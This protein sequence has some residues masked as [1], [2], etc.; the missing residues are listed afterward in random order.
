METYSLPILNSGA[1]Y[2]S[3]SRPGPKTES[4]ECRFEVPAIFWFGSSKLQCA[5][6]CTYNQRKMVNGYLV[7]RTA[8]GRIY[9]FVVHCT[10][11][12]SSYFAYPFL[13]RWNV[14]HL[15]AHDHNFAMLSRDII[16][17]N[18]W[19]ENK[20]IWKSFATNPL[21]GV[22]LVG[23]SRACVLWIHIL[24]VSQF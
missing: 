4:L 24:P 13:T 8:N 14:Q 1:F 12:V 20:D 7:L 22:I 18:D 17:P 3:V 16:F 19:Q 2:L 5:S 21:H 23:F 9:N 6:R 11:L 10:W 15:Q